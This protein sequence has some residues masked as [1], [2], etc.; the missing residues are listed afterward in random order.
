MPEPAAST[1]SI[2]ALAPWYGSN[3]IA[4]EA[5]G[6]ALGRLDWCGVPFAGGC[7]EIPWIRTRAGVGNDL[8][9][10][11]INLARVAA[12]QDLA[13]Q[14]AHRVSGML[15]HPDELRM[16]QRRCSA[17]ETPPRAG[18]FAGPASGP[19]C[20]TAP[21]V[22]WA[23]DYFVCCW[24]G[25]SAIAGTPSEFRSAISTRW[26]SSGGDSARRFRSAAESLRAWHR[27]LTGWSFMTL[28]AFDFLSFCRDEAGH[29]VYADAPWPD[30]GDGYTHHFTAEQQRR[31]AARLATFERARVVIR[32]GDHPLI[33]ELYADRARWDW[34]EST[35]RGQA[36]NEVAEVLIT[37][38]P[39]VGG[40]RP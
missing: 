1:L 6:I 39:I 18:L 7:C 37:N 4:P 30:A 20:D 40:P 26:T 25:R 34:T 29:G 17:R 27:M 23:T 21:S 22:E 36:G 28:D 13:E 24:M 38:T 16:A 10:H 32:Y 33:R 2:G 8:H 19:A 9:R 31:L 3:R 11:L 5:V 14:V 35:T 15:F 12:D